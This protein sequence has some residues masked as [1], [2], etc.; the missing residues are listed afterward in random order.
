ME[1]QL[2]GTKEDLD[3]LKLSTKEMSDA[4][5]K[6]EATLAEKNS[7]INKLKEGN[8]AE[9]QAEKEKRAKLEQLLKDRE[10]MA[11]TV[12]S[13][14]TNGS[15]PTTVSIYECLEKCVVLSFLLF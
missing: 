3:R 11:S 9:L 15:A 6:L 12:S 4:K 2:K 7:E 13:P 8:S 10:S 14:T 1:T 5:S